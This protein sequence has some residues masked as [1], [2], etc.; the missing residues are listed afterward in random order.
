MEP[1]NIATTTGIQAATHYAD[2]W[3]AA[4]PGAGFSETPRFLNVFQDETLTPKPW[5]KTLWNLYDC[6]KW[7]R[8]LAHCP[9]IAYS[10]EVDRQ[11][12]AADVM[13]EA[14][15]KHGIRLRH[16]IGAGM[17][18]RYDDA[19]KA[20]VEDVLNT[21][22]DKGR[23]VSSHVTFETSTL[24]YNRMQWIQVNGLKQHFTPAQVEARHFR[25]KS[26]ESSTFFIEFIALQN[27]TDVS[28]SL[29][30]GT[31]SGPTSAA[32]IRWRIRDGEEPRRIM[33]SS[34]GSVS[35]RIRLDSAG[36]WRQVDSDPDGL[37]KRHNLQGP[38]DDALMDSFVF[39]R[40][41]GTAANEAAGKWATSELDRAIEHWRRHFR[42]DARVI[43]DT[44]VTDELAQQ[45]NL[46]LWGD[47]SSNSVMAK[48]ADKLPI[49]WNKDTITVGDNVYSSANHAPVLI[50]PNPMNP[51][52]YVVLNSSFT[53]REYAYLNNAR[54]V[55]M[56]PDWA[57]INLDTPAGTVW[58][59]EVVD[60]DF[61]D[62]TW[63]LSS[64]SR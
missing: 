48:I 30:A 25:G 51:G 22:A 60:A 21:L 31:I 42:G 47:P 1:R 49:Q 4:N 18:H 64:R 23:E 28:V 5:E 36:V 14:L 50:Y 17:G 57:I 54:Q 44:D 53:F 15:A 33:A 27:V 39:V 8:N 9:T 12:Q 40:P 52:R 34:D 38:I 61:F 11:K 45:A 20:I 3:F 10:G 2:R 26:G 63:Q 56:L 58:P 24:K 37:T 13:E 62:E 59:G 43:D 46:I 55:P 32:D 6:D 7:A 19:S 41:T 16:I 29:P 35:L